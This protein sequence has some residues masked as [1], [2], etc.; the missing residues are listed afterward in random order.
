LS[1]E[2]NVTSHPSEGLKKNNLKHQAVV[3]LLK[4]FEIS[5]IN[6]MTAALE[7]FADLTQ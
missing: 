1:Q 6:L 4:T 7:Y 3:F 5:S 2:L